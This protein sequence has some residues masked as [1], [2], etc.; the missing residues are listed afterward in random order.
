MKK[1]IVISFFSIFLQS[2][3]SILTVNP[4]SLN[5]DNFLDFSNSCFKVSNVLLINS[6]F[7]TDHDNISENEKNREE[8]INLI[9]SLF[10]NQSPKQNCTRYRTEVKL[11]NAPVN[12]RRLL[13]ILNFITLGIIPYWDTHTNSLLVDIYDIN[14]NF[15]KRVRS[16]LEYS[17]IQSIFLLPVSPFFID[18]NIKL[19]LTTIPQHFKNLELE[20]LNP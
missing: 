2:C 17:R 15:L 5:K 1:C 10:D 19:N 6:V 12:D 7:G 11:Q 14:G 18:S 20:N 9:K 13:L 3:A 8:E 4:N 16:T